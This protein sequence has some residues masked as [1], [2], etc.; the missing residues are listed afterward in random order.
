MTS[1]ILAKRKS[2]FG[3]VPFAVMAINGALSTYIMVNGSSSLLFPGYM[4]SNLFLLGMIGLMWTSMGLRPAAHPALF[5]LGFVPDWLNSL[6]L[7]PQ[8]IWS[9]LFLAA[10]ISLFGHRRIPRWASI[11]LLISSFAG[12]TLCKFV[13]LGVEPSDYFTKFLP[14]FGIASYA[15]LFIIDLLSIEP[16]QLGVPDGELSENEAVELLKK[17]WNAAY[18]YRVRPAENEILTEEL[19]API[20]SA[21]PFLARNTRKHEGG[22]YPLIQLYTIQNAPIL[23]CSYLDIR[24]DQQAQ[25]KLSIQLEAYEYGMF[26]SNDEVPMIAIAPQRLSNRWGTGDA[27]PLARVTDRVIGDPMPEVQFDTEVPILE[28]VLVAAEPQPAAATASPAASMSSNEAFRSKRTFDP[29]GGRRIGG[30]RKISEDGG[31]KDFQWNVP[32]K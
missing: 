19:L 20:L 7:D 26:L 27:L 2:Q 22:R 28:E 11:P 29:K 25:Q 17:N 31:S 32:S 30:L 15:V 13:L 6:A 23:E 8:G 1:K 12:Y 18:K 21:L 3:S 5:F 14:A 4:I 24:E 9:V 10:S 16:E